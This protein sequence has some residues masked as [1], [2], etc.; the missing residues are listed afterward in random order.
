M[1]FEAALKALRSP[2]GVVLYPTETV[3]GLGCRASDSAGIEKINALKQAGR[4]PQIVLVDGVP[5]WLEGL[6]KE[7]AEAFWPGP[8]TLIVRPPEGLFVGARAPDS[9]LAI[10]WS[11]HPVV[12]ALVGGVGPITS[13]SANIHGSPPVRIPADLAFEVDAVVDMGQ[14]PDAKPSTLVDVENRTVLRKGELFETVER[15]MS[16]ALSE[17]L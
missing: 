12:Q 6:A 16:E 4:H 3:Y 8:L 15:V 14:L 13:T 7:L 11:P 9:T 1:E 5:T 17:R 2:A 10:R